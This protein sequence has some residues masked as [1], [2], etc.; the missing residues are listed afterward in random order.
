MKF[1]AHTLEDDPDPRHWQTLEAHL[2]GVAEKAGV[3]AEAFG[4]E[5]WG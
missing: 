2:Y 1:Y 5:E 3:F 4:A